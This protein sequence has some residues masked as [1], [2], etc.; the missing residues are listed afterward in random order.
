MGFW[1]SGVF[2]LCFVVLFVFSG[3]VESQSNVDAAAMAALA[4]SIGSNSLGWTGS[5]YCNNW[6]KVTCNKNTN[7]VTK[8]QLGN[9]NLKGSLP[10]EIRNLTELEQFEVQSNRLTGQFPSFSGL[11]SL[12]VLLAHDN[13]F[14]S[15]PA[16][17]FNGLTSLENLSIDDNPFSAWPIPESLKDAT[18]LKQFSA[19]SANVVGK[20][21]DFLGGNN[22]PAL[23]ELRL[24]FNNLEGE[25]PLSFS[26]SG[27]QSLWLNGQQGSN[28]LNG[29]IAVLQNMTDL[30][31]VW[32]HGNQFT[33][34][35]PDLS[36]LI[37]L[38]Q[39]SLRDN[40]FTGIVP[41]TLTKLPSLSVVNLTNN[42]LQ[43]PTPQFGNGV[44]VDM[45][46]GDN[47]F[48]L[49]APGAPCDTRID[50]L[51]SIVQ[52]MHY[53]AVFGNAWKGN[54]PCANW[55]GV[56]CVGK[57]ITVINFRNL[58]LVGTI[59]PNFS[60]LIALKTL[61]VADNH[62]TGT[63]PDELTTLK[64]LSAVDVSNNLLFGK[65]PS[66]RSNVAVNTDGNPDIGK[67][68]SSVPPPPG[69]PGGGSTPGTDGGK[70]SPTGA[71]NKSK[72][73]VVVGVVMGSV[74]GLLVIGAMAFFLMTRRRKHSG[75]VQ[76][77]NA[78][79][80]HPRYSGD[81]QDAVKIT[82]AN[83]ANGS[84]SEPYSPTS[85]RQNDVQVVEAGNMVISIQLLRDVT[86]NFSQD[87]ILGRGGFGTVYKGELHDGTQIAVKRMESV[88]VAEKGLT[89][90]MSEI[91]VLTKVRHRHLVAL[92]G[93]CLDGNE[94]LLVYEYMPQ[95]TV[96]RYLFNWREEDLE[97]LEWSR[98]LIIALDV[99]RGVEYLHGLA[100]QTFIHRDLKPSNI[101]LGDDMRA[102][103][104]DFG[105]VRLAPEGKASFQTC[106]AGTFGYLAPEYAGKTFQ[107][108]LHFSLMLW[109]A[110]LFFYD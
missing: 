40:Q 7:R 89:E 48:C 64:Q 107:N 106:L 87:S 103:V 15:F 74:G 69:A 4:K 110:M 56:S 32:L 12:R 36:K 77:P 66:F 45:K 70:D 63:I 46:A 23:T 41:P 33:G 18:M 57:D 19:G 101:L 105:L 2:T 20:I 50:D 102:K 43:G 8:I 71:N 25:L 83:R 35:I 75:R 11:S 62:L 31:D 88:G 3:L 51:L 28:K 16:D 73:G 72:T 21:P 95:G 100:H 39:F 104:A 98:R 85:S 47:S 49:D 27:I 30:T 84:G 80:I 6:Q 10:P 58:G 29:T 14:S 42:L 60:K 65:V 53:P 55:R 24:S 22:F 90:F 92:L 97:P 93:Y 5:D 67:N 81:D 82:V 1:G 108:V 13:N 78:V 61:N 96:S 91:N 52:S 68:T 86:N 44:T 9:Q 109:N 34:P 94:R 26:G 38:K 17:F 79:V 99:A 37:G 59:S 76:S 54:D